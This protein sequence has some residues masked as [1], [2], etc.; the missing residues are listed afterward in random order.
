MQARL[1]PRVCSVSRDSFIRKLARHSGALRSAP[2][3]SL[4]AVHAAEYRL[5]PREIPFT[6]HANP[7]PP[8]WR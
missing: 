7:L 4:M 5:H 2:R 1:G 8:R 6:P 3:L